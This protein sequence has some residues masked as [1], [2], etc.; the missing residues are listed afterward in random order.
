MISRAAYHARFAFTLVELL[1]VIT[2]VALLAALVGLAV[3]S[4][5]DAGRGAA[6]SSNLQQIGMGI[7]TYASDHDGR[8]P[9]GPKAGLMMSAGTLYPATGSPTSLIS[10][11]SGEPVALGLTIKYLR[12]PRVL[13]CPGADQVIDAKKELAKVGHDEAQCS[14]FYRH[15]SNT[16][17]R[18]TKATS[19]DPPNIRLGNLGENRK[20]KPVRA[21]VIDTIFISPPGMEQFNVTT[22]T[23]HRQKFANVLFVDGHVARMQN[24]LGKLS[25]DVHQ[26]GDLR[27][28]FDKILAVLERADEGL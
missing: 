27:A 17:L 25:V 11:G 26:Y 28:S 6:C 9:F 22:R 12:D 10:L 19:D 3:Q 14:Y 8:I 13:F 21:L 7:G 4:A 2:V 20:G 23:N 5:M 16:D 1:V 18:D 24:D 15:G